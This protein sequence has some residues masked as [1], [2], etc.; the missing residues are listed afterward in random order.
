MA[1]I[2][3]RDVR[4]FKR[5]GT[6]ATSNEIP[7]P[8][9]EIIQDPNPATPNPGVVYTRAEYS[10]RCR[11][12]RQ[13]RDTMTRDA[14]YSRM[15]AQITVL[16][17]LTGR[18]EYEAKEA[19]AEAAAVAKALHRRE[20]VEAAEN[21]WREEHQRAH[22]PRQPVGIHRIPPI[23]PLGRRTVRNEPLTEDDL[24]LDAG[25]PRFVRWPKL[26]HT[27]TI[28]QGLKSYPVR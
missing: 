10:A 16:A 27:C 20:R 15:V 1:H 25:R 5:N 22:P 26:E 23:D 19:A 9:S 21:L 18:A 17:E 14:G 11:V 2:P 4:V 8:A 6:L 13:L 7:G 3:R 12:I 24:Y 28:C